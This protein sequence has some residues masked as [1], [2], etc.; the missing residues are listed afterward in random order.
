MVTTTCSAP[1][2]FRT[3]SVSARRAM[4]ELM[5]RIGGVTASRSRVTGIDWTFAPTV[6]VVRDDRWG[7]TYEG[8][9]EDPEIVRDYAGRMVRGSAGR[10]RAAAFLMRDHV[11]A[12]AKHFIGDGGT[13]AGIDAAT[14]CRRAAAARHP[15]TGLRR[16]ARTPAHRP[17]WPRTTAGRAGKLHGQQHCSPTCSR[18]SMGFDGMLVSDWDGID[19]VQ[20]CSKDSAPQAVNAG[21]DMFMV[22]TDWKPCID[23]HDP[24]VRD[25]RH[26]AGA[27]R[28]CR[29]AHSAR[30]AARRAVRERASLRRDRSHKR[31]SC[32]ARRASRCGATGGAR[33]AGA[34]EEQERR[35]AAAAR[36]ER[37]GGRKQRRR[38]RQANRRLDDHLA[39]HGQHER[40]IS[41]ARPR[42]SPA[43]KSRGARTAAAR[44]TLSVTAT[45]ATRPDVAI[46]VFGESRTRM[47]RQRQIDRLSGRSGGAESRCSH[48]QAGRASGRVGLSD[49]PA[50]V[51]ESRAGNASDAF[52]DRMAARQRRDGGIADVM[53]SKSRP[54]EP[55][56]PSASCRYSWPRER[57]ADH[58]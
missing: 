27:H 11:M 26:S 2:C 34:A 50:A 33:I 29:H 32:S 36:S 38:H 15:R 54:G 56:F 30:E 14:T 52:V 46:V 37:S 39:G 24:Q 49:R 6:A 18:R 41:P 58:C 3:T 57:C 17:S 21:I 31:S 45:Y 19:E 20:G 13:E 8:Y 12:T 1:R 7:R 44:A 25:G 9:S 16:R 40:A 51:G 42:S 10:R 22:P 47:A 55:R 5:E 35:A 4:P 53:F 48:A 28:R 43:F 23:E